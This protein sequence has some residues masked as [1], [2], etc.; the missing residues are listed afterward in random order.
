[1]AKKKDAKKKDSAMAEEV[2][3]A[4]EP[5]EPQEQPTEPQEQEQLD[6][7]DIH[8]ENAKPIIAAARIYKKLVGKRLDVLAQEVEQKQKI[9]DLVKEA[10]LTPLENGVVRFK[11]DNVTISITP[12]DEL[13]KV[14]DENPTN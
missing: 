12:R 2:K 9:L 4:E 3:K 5:Q 8:P 7:I 1:M 6:L 14:K 10:K 11:Y 13:V